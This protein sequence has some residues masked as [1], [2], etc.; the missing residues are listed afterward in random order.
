[1]LKARSRLTFLTLVKHAH[2]FKPLF[3]KQSEGAKLQD[4]FD[5]ARGSLFSKDKSERI[6]TITLTRHSPQRSDKS[7]QCS[8]V[9]VMGHLL[10]PRG[11][12]HISK[13]AVEE[14]VK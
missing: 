1:M 13:Q 12:A 9:S 7:C 5:F 6:G 2:G 10:S 8:F 11:D 3:I 4:D 14:D